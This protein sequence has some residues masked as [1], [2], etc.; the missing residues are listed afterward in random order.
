MIGTLM[1]KITRQAVTMGKAMVAEVHS[2]KVLVRRAEGVYWPMIGGWRLQTG[3]A[4]E[5]LAYCCA[6]AAASGLPSPSTDGALES[7]IF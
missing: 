5:L 4:V 7:A 2:G 1:T 6:G 3:A